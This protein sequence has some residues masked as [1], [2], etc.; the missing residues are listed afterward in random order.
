M[1]VT[2]AGC[3]SD[4]TTT[5]GNPSAGDT[6]SI[7]DVFG[8]LLD[9]LGGDGVQLD[10][11]SGELLGDGS[12]D[13]TVKVCEFGSQPLAGQPGAPCSTAADC[14]SAVCI[15][16]P[17]GKTCTVKCTDCCPSGWKCGQVGDADPIFA[18]LPKALH[19]CDPCSSDEACASAGDAALCVTYAGVGNFCGSDC[20]EAGTCP[21]GYTCSDSKGVKGSGKQC[22]RDTATCECSKKASESGLSGTCVA[23]NSFGTCTGT[24]TCSTAGLSECNA[25]AAAAETC[26]G[27]DDNCDGKTD[28]AGASGCKVYWVDGDDDGYGGSEATGGTSQ[29]LCAK[30]APYVSA[31]STDC[32]DTNPGVGPFAVE[33]CDD[34]DNDCDGQTDEDCDDDKDGYCHAKMEVVGKPKTCPKGGGDCEDNLAEAHPGAV[35]LCGNA[36]DDDCNGMTD[37]E[38]NATGCAKFYFD[39]DKDAWGSGPPKCLCAPANSFTAGQDGDCADGDATI[40][41]AAK[42]VCGN[43]KDDNCNGNTD[44]DE[45]ATG[46]KQ[47]YID[48]D[49]DGFGGGA[50]KCLCGAFGD[51]AN[52]KGGDCDDTKP[53]Y[54]PGVAE[55]CTGS[56]PTAKPV[57]ENCDGQTDEQNATGCTTFYADVDGDKF[58]DSTDFKCLCAPLGKYTATVAGDCEDT[59]PAVYPT[60]VETCN[61]IDDNCNFVADEVGANGCTILYADIDQDGAGNPNQTACMCQKSAPYVAAAGDDCDDT[62]KEIHPKAVEKCNGVDDTCDGTTDEE[63]AA[64]CSQ[65]FLDADGDQWGLKA[66]VKCLCAPAGSYTA[67]KVDD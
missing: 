23:S 11:L 15:D 42:E 9:S 4:P 56:D 49:L 41:P 43:G 27:K 14:D 45:G 7:K 13:A 54:N 25:P 26:N 18:C 20:S 64:G 24:R 8:S 67:V 44:A 62:N 12:A 37:S 39:S 35:E 1:A 55:V 29:C 40:S 5:T 36:I 38:E 47:Y 22:I 34:L 66:S 10:S 63:G 3:S 32:D 61:G 50:G 17:N 57:D 51:Y 6:S 30:V 46:C 2:A 33:K 48:T 60:A 65:F 59:K 58:G 28:E 52:T 53:A 31:T 16:T 19:L 21:P